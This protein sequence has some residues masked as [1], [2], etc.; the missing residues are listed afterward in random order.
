[1]TLDFSGYI[2]ERMRDFTGREWVFQAIDDWLGDPAAPSFFIVTGPPGSGK[3]AIAAR[4]TQ[5][6]DVAASHFCTA[7][8]ASNTLEPVFFAR[9]LCSQLCRIDGFAAAMLKDSNID[10]HAVQ[11]I[12]ANY[13]QAIAIKIEN[14]T[15][16]APS[17]AA[18]F[19]HTVVE[20]LKVLCTDGFA[21]S[22]VLL[23][24]GLDEA[25]QLLSPQTIVGLLA[26]AGAW[27]RPVRWLLTSRPDSAVLSAFEAQPVKRLELGEHAEKNLG[28]VRKYMLQQATHSERASELQM[29][30]AEH[31]MAPEALATRV[32]QASG[33]NFLYVVWLLR[34]IAEGA[35]RLDQLDTLPQGLDGIYR[36]FLRTRTVGK[37]QREWR[38]L[39]RPLLG[40]LAAAQAPLNRAQ[41]LQFTG[42]DAQDL[43]DGL[44]DVGQFLDPA[45]AREDR[46]Q[47]YHQSLPDFLGDR[48]RAK[49]FWIDPA[50]WH[51]QI[52]D[53]Y[54]DG[55]HPNWH[56]LKD[57]YGLDNLA[58]HLYHGGQDDRLREL[59]SQQWMTARLEGSGHAYDGFLG[60]VMLAWRQAHKEAQG[61]IEAGQA[62]A[63]LAE[64]VRYALIRT[65]LNSLEAHCDPAL[66]ARA[67]ETGLWPVEQALFVAH[68]EYYP[69]YRVDMFAALLA[70]GRL[71]PEQSTRAQ[72]AGLAE[73][74]AIEDWA[75]RARALAR[76]A[77]HLSGQALSRGLAAA[78]AIEEEYDMAWALSLAGAAPG[79]WDR[80]DLFAALLAT[81]RLG[82]EQ[83]AQAQEAGLAAAQAIEV[84][85]RAQALAILMP[86]LSGEAHTKAVKRGRAAA[87]GLKG[88]DQV[89]AL[90]A[91]APQLSG[92]AQTQA[93][94]QGLKAALAIG[95]EGERAWALA[96]LAPQLSGQALEQALTAALNIE[97]QGCRERALVALAPHLSGEALGR[98]LVAL[99]PQVSGEALERGL[100]V[101]LAVDDEWARAEA[102]VW[103]VPQ[104]KGETLERGLE[105]TLAIKDDP[106]RAWAL[107]ALVPRLSG[108]ARD[109]AVE[110][111]LA[112]ARGIST[113]LWRAEALAA[114]APQLSGKA[115]EQELPAAL[116][117]KDECDEARALAALAP[118][119]SGEA[120]DR[121]V[122]RGLA[123]ALVVDK[124]YR[125]LKQSLAAAQAEGQSSEIDRLQSLLRR[126]PGPWEQVDMFAALLATGRL[127]PNESTQAQEAGLAAALAIEDERQRARAL[128]ALAP[129]LTGEARTQA[130]TRGLEA[131]Q[132]ITD[133]RAQAEALAAPAPQ[134]SGEALEQGLAAALDI[135]SEQVRAAALLA[136]LPVAP[137]PAAVLCSVRQ[138]IARHLLKNL[139]AA[140]REE[141]LRFCAEKK[142]FAPPLLDQTTLDAIVGHIIEVCQE[143]RWM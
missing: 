100:A 49:E 31:A 38:G 14:L 19:T 67:V 53:F 12:Q 94:T 46:Y 142:L 73:A 102:L 117:I 101:A 36:E 3:S 58:S 57:A 115:L 8:D 99:A 13:G 42:L 87:R 95:D 2:A 92:E 118:Q 64:C 5:V 68:L 63:A 39:Y 90:A 44:Q 124:R 114:L 137:D 30:L 82:P 119:L 60:D 6:R 74:L 43:E 37:G 34:G 97:E 1:M 122:E 89:S 116:D 15:V 105:A 86:Q 127:G 129:R 107:V 17:A 120:R 56:K 80:V 48:K 69:R 141:V 24:D 47:L 79:P 52:A 18:A 27:P 7:R 143:W 35:Q 136:F 112:A 84:A 72:E 66:V 132:G 140:K 106:A 135:E 138:A 109:R 126:E 85:R 51:R 41:L 81:D 21:G 50:P 98:A 11:N 20:P 76:L 91:L 123:A 26:N 54:W 32:A 33:G 134:L 62:P 130:L 125:E 133:E 131:A 121:A 40:A 113:E 111:G 45:S 88:C 10:L 55:D 139:S 61:Q 93:L 23:V 22:V 9:S 128:E 16:N 83:S 29:R 108:K 75:F 104:L 103:L 70:T 25:A 71:S 110:R 78:L 28:D 96:A 59:I 65:S 4:L 77:P